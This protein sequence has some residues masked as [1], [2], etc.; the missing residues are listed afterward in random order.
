MN[1]DQIIKEYITLYPT[2]NNSKIAGLIMD[3]EDTDL[4]HRTLRRKIGEYRTSNDFCC[5][6]ASIK[7]PVKYFIDH[8]PKMFTKELQPYLRGDLDNVLI[9]GDPHEPFCLEGYMAHCLEQQKRFN[10]GTVICIGD[11][12]DNHYSSFHDADPDGKGAGDE[13]ELTI[14]K[15][16]EWHRLFPNAICTIGNHDAIIMR[17][18]FASG[19]SK[20]WIKGLS[21]VLEMPTWTFVESYEYNGIL[22]THT[23]GGNLLNA[24][25]ARRQSVV[26]GHLHTKA[27]IQW[28]VNK[29]DRIFSMQ[30]GCGIDDKAYAFAY[31]KLVAKKSIISCGVVLNDIPVI[32]PMNL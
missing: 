32:I 27:E 5:K 15:T 11:I 24:A 29:Y 21:E 9:I 30:V 7:K 31:A 19:V 20:R 1:I 3:A 6:E 8:V 17:K 13:L 4:S 25:M 23:L 28:N 22:Y 10:C 12:I 18:A 2:K 14:R 26:C 16:R